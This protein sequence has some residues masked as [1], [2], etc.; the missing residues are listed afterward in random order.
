MHNFLSTFYTWEGNF[1]FVLWSQGI[2]KA[3][4]WSQTHKNNNLIHSYIL[5]HH[6]DI[7][8]K[9]RKQI[10]FLFGE[11]SNNSIHV[12]YDNISDRIKLYIGLYHQDLRWWLEIIQNIKDNFA[13]KAP[14]LLEPDFLKLDCVWVDFSSD[15]LDIK[16]YELLK[17]RWDTIELLGINNSDIKEVGVLKNHTW[18]KKKFYRFWNLQDISVFQ[19]TFDIDLIDDFQKKI[20]NFYVF[21]KQVKYY[22]TEEGKK[23]IYF[24]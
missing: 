14:Y 11:Y 6:Q 23:E 15:M 2:S 19:D 16:I 10:D 5:T 21:K 13:I 24:I 20:K 22:C 7:Y 8:I 18:R 17:I 9:Y 4:F 1:E 12:W 3:L